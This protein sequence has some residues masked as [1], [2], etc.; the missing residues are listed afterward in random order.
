MQFEITILRIGTIGQ[1]ITNGYVGSH[2]TELGSWRASGLAMGIRISFR[3][4]NQGIN[5]GL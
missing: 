3:L 4:R 5:G 1:I 2:F